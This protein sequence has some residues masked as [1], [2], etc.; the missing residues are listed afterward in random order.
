MLQ[1]S[2]TLHPPTGLEGDETPW[3]D[4]SLRNPWWP[5]ISIRAD[6][7]IARSHDNLSAESEPYSDRLS[8][9]ISQLCQRLCRPRLL[10]LDAWGH[11]RAHEDETR[12]PEGLDEHQ[13]DLRTTKTQEKQ[14]NSPI[15]LE[16]LSCWPFSTSS[17]AQRR[18]R[19]RFRA[20]SSL[21]A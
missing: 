5:P 12:R 8:T 20:Y 6:P 10:R 1:K 4:Y 14:Y 9:R 2:Q 16:V 3:W 13:G 7:R 15:Y 21:H 11:Q 19:L 18:R 17:A